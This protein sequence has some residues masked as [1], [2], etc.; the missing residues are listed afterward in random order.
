M[1]DIEEMAKGF[2]RAMELKDYRAAHGITRELVAHARTL[3][4]N[5]MSELGD[6]LER[7]LV[8]SGVYAAAPIITAMAVLAARIDTRN[9]EFMGRGLQS[10][11]LHIDL[12]TFRSAS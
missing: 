8:N 10:A 5:D 11:V 3:G 1:S 4:E 2:K 6:A 9:Q 12:A 7:Q